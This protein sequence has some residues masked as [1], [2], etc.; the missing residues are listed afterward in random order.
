[1]ANKTEVR[2]TANDYRK[3]QKDL[4]KSMIKFGNEVTARLFDLIKNNPDLIVGL[5]DSPLYNGCLKTE[6]LINTFV[7]INDRIYF[8]DVIEKRLAEK[9]KYVQGKLFN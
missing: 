7:G 1:M 6:V 3:E 2:K 4:D 8:I 5:F 9:E